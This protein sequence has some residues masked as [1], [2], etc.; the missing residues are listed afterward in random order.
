M[1]IILKR[2]PRECWINQYNPDLLEAWNANIDVQFVVDGYSCIA[3]IVSYISK[4]ESEE[5]E[6]LKA[7]QREAREGNANALTELRKIGRV[8]LTHREVSSMEAIWRATG[9]M[10][11]NCSREIKWVQSDD[12]A[13]R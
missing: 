10:L 7:A 13:T 12:E 1:S 6:L 3:Y 5:G 8:Y 11:K 9:M 2:E 4:K